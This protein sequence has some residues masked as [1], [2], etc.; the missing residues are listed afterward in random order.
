MSADT[1]S[2]SKTTSTAARLVL[3]SASPR[4]RDLLAA[5]GYE[6]QVVPA[7]V[8]ESADW[9]LSVRER[10]LLNAVR[11]SAVGQQW[12]P[13]TVVVGVDTL[14]ALDGEALGKPPDRARAAAM[15]ARLSG[16]THQVFTGVALREVRRNRYVSFVEESRVTFLPLDAAQI[17]AYH[18]LINPLDKAGGYAAQDHGEKII[19]ALAGSWTNVMGLPM[20]RLAEVLAREFGI[21]PTR[22]TQENDRQEKSNLPFSYPLAPA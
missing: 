17:E 4:R 9:F 11:K 1:G 6:A 15:V 14:V 3:A 20:E 7:D 8:E 16:R 2:E 13:Q 5:Y 22:A 18:T 19:A 10:V 12:P 21:R